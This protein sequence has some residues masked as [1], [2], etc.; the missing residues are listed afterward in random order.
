MDSGRGSE[1]VAEA[2]D[3]HRKVAFLRD[4]ANHAERPASV[5]VVETHMSWVFLTDQY[6]YKFKKPVNLPHMRFATLEARQGNCREEVRLNARLAQG[7]YVGV[8]PLVLCPS[9]RLVIDGDGTPVEWLVKM[10]RLPRSA[11]LD[12]ALS[13]GTAAPD[14]VRGAM[15]VLTAF[16]RQL[17]PALSDPAAYIERLRLSVEEHAAALDDAAFPR[18]A[19]GAD[20]PLALTAFLE[21]HEDLLAARVTGGHIVEGHGDLRPEHVCLTRPPVFIDC[22]EFSRDLRILDVADELAYLAL[23]CECLNAAFVGDIAFRVY[24]E[25]TGDVPPARVIAFYK[26]RRGL[27]RARLCLS[28]LA[29][30]HGEASHAK[31]TA[32]A[33]MYMDAAARYCRT[34]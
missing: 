8:V 13:H 32:R 22:L 4:P 11:M 17:S 27:L 20:V 25:V 29:D 7:V 24:R 9:G 6:V 16:Y 34:L 3:T 26:A 30:H 1:S 5:E 14:D 31:W 33:R 23:E 2:A 18:N 19:A 12:E 15:G 10:H 28:H 21:R